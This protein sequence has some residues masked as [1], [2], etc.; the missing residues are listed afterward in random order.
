MKKL[1]LVICILL[2]SSAY[3]QQQE[4][5]DWMIGLT[6][7]FH[8]VERNGFKTL[9]SM[10]TGVSVGYKGI[11]LNLYAGILKAT[12]YWQEHSSEWEVTPHFSLGYQY[13]FG[14]AY[15][16]PFKPI[17]G[18]YLGNLWELDEWDQVD[19]DFDLGFRYKSI[20]FLLAPHIRTEKSRI[21]IPLRDVESR[22]VLLKFKIQYVF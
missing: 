10:W 20:N 11:S 13:T 21:L 5:K 9:Q 1:S 19:M 4:N 15:D 6:L 2:G 17:I 8:Q 7:P 3:A 18:F 12:L 22:N 16:S 14:K